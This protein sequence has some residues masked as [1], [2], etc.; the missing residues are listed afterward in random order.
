M[1]ITKSNPVGIDN[2]IQRLN[3]MLYT[4]LQTIWSLTESQIMAYARV[5]K[6]DN[7]GKVILRRFVSDVVYK[8]VLLDDSYALTYFFL[9]ED[10]S[11]SIESHTIKSNV[12][13]CFFVNLTT[14][15][16]AITHRADEEVKMDVYDLLYRGSEGLNGISTA[17]DLPGFE[18]KFDIQPFHS[19][20][21]N[22]KLNYRV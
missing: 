15:K 9:E 11:R 7:K 5:Y 13:V 12:D 14:V 6:I 2:R 1:I 3:G 21:F 20:K 16:P 19:F 22:I 4:Q 8:D 10:G 18:S 17:I